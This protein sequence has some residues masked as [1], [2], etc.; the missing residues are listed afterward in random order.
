MC[1]GEGKGSLIT[2]E[3]EVVENGYVISTRPAGQGYVS[4]PIAVATCKNSLVRVVGDI[5]VANLHPA[6]VS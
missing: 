3:I 4:R 6:R 2:L 5:L 1:N